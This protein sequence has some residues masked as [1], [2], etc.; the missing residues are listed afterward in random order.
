MSS[1]NVDNGKHT[2]ALASATGYTHI[3]PG[4]LLRGE[5]LR[6]SEDGLM[7]ENM[8]SSGQI[9]P[10]DVTH[11]LIQK[12]MTNSGN[13]RFI[14]DLYPRALD[15]AK[16]FEEQIGRCSKV[17]YYEASDENVLAR[18]KAK[19]TNEDNIAR[20]IRTFKSQT[21]PVLNYY[22][23]QGRVKQVDAIRGR[24]NCAASQ[25]LR[26]HKSAVG[27]PTKAKQCKCLPKNSNCECINGNLI[28]AANPKFPICQRPKL[29]EEGGLFR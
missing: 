3:V 4:N 14:V 21:V 24:R 2:K 8:T 17:L 10:V 19:D 23:V 18:H 9:I 7:L 16:R 28:D 27:A 1:G 20:R 22:G 15:Q 5:M 25:E 26:M 13:D 6:K 11:S 29:R 12:A